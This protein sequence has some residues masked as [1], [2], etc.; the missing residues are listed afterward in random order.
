MAKLEITD[1]LDALLAVLPPPIAAALQ[2][3]NR[4]ED[5]LEIVLDLGRRPEARFVDQE[6]ELSK[7]EVTQAEIDYV[8]SRIGA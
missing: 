4:S 1:D 8:V 3:A 7:Q 2:A 5:L 6:I